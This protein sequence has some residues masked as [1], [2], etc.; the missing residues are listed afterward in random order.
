MFV[1]GFVSGSEFVS[2]LEL[3]KVLGFVTQSLKAFV[4]PLGFESVLG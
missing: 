2:E 4:L 3:S 1:L